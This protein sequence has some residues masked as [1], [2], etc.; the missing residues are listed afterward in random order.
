M[1]QEKLLLK[2]SITRLKD[3]AKKLKKEKNIQLSSTRPNC[4]N[5]RLQQLAR[6]STS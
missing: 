3:D 1:N 2:R 5:G 4:P 6:I